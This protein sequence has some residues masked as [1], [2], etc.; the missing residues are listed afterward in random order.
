MGGGV[1]VLVLS[2]H[3]FGFASNGAAAHVA[4][5]QPVEFRAITRDDGKATM[6]F[7]PAQINKV[8]VA[9]TEAFYA[10]EVALS[11]ENVRQVHEGHT[12]LTVELTPKSMSTISV[13]VFEMPATPP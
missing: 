13:H 4:S 2:M 12:M 9:E 10:R 3:P 11:L 1:E 5:C 7:L 8:R 6:C